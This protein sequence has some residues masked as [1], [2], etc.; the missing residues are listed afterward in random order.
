MQFEERREKY[1]H[2]LPERFAD[3]QQWSCLQ[4]NCN[5]S[6]KSINV[7]FWTCYYIVQRTNIKMW[8]N[9]AWKHV[10]TFS[11]TNCW[12]GKLH[13][14]FEM[15]LC[16]RTISTVANLCL[17]C[18]FIKEFD[19]ENLICH[20]VTGQRFKDGFYANIF[21]RKLNLQIKGLCEAMLIE[22]LYVS[23]IRSRR[24]K[25]VASM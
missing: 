25:A 15:Q 22:T 12:N 17:V 20:N 23:W 4:K 24:N 7:F 13:V 11:E 16:I 19:P 6:P 2:L 5:W 21:N 10:N 3:V 14:C 1:K 8:Q 9:L 18:W